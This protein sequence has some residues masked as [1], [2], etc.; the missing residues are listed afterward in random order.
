MNDKKLYAF[1][2]AFV[3]LFTMTVGI[4]VFRGPIRNVTRAGQDIV[5]IERSV[6]LASTLESSIS[7]TPVTIT[8]FVRNKDGRT[9]DSKA[10]S[11]ST[12][13]G[14]LDVSQGLTDKYGRVIF[15]LS[16]RV[17]GEALIS[18]VI[19]G[20][21]TSQPLTIKFSEQPNN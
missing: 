9:L 4:A 18:G 17:P 7:G 2:F 10:V 14:S 15:K 12:T 20:Q 21:Q 13:L 5:S 16:S 3:L 8:V 6:L 19:D 11:L 1:F